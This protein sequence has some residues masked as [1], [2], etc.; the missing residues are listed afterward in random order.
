MTFIAAT[1]LQK[2]NTNEYLQVRLK[3]I[4]K[5]GECSNTISPQFPIPATG[6][7]RGA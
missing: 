4:D 2:N 5:K 1:K 6:K 7:S 3:L